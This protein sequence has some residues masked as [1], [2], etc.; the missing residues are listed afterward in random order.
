MSVLKRI[1]HALLGDY[2]LY[3]IYA[4]ELNK[5]IS[6]ETSLLQFTPIESSIVLA[7]SDS[8]A[9]RNLV[10]YDQR[11]F[12]FGFGARVKDILVAACWFWAGRTYRKRNFWPLKEDEAKLVQISTHE[13]FRGRGYAP[14]LLAYAAEAMRLKG[15]TKLFARVWHSNRASVSAFEKAHWK[16]I[17]FVAEVYPLG[18][19]KALRLRWRKPNRATNFLV[20]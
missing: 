20:E 15:Y 1:A 3:R 8:E 16:Y 6:Y 7:E 9:I 2:A 5:K 12:A 10:A 19:K 13:N 4:L 17:A 14:L 18:K 11:E